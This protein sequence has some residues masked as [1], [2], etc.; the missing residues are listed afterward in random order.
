MIGMR[1]LG[2]KSFQREFSGQLI[3]KGNIDFSDGAAGV[4]DLDECVRSFEPCGNSF[5]VFGDGVV[6]PRLRSAFSITV[7]AL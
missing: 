6:E 3:V 5:V 2:A 1:Q 4:K 7:G